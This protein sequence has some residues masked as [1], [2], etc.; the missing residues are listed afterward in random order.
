MNEKELTQQ[1]VILK[2]IIRRCN[3][4]LICG[5]EF[6]DIVCKVCNSIGEHKKD[7]EYIKVI[8]EDI[9]EY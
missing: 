6:T 7:C 3:P 9:E 8:N 1:I 2:R 5:R 4:F